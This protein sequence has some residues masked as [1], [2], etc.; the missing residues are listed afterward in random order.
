MMMFAVDD[1]TQKW[2]QTENEHWIGFCV[3]NVAIYFLKFEEVKIEGDL[4][5]SRETQSDEEHPVNVK[6]NKRFSSVGDTLSSNFLFFVL[7][8]WFLDIVTKDNTR[9]MMTDDGKQVTTLSDV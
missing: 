7:L 1:P 2:E 4:M 3:W 9:R 8:V 6:E 5:P